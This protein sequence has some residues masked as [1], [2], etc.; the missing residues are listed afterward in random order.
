MSKHDIDDDELEFMNKV[1]D[2]IETFMTQSERYIIIPGNDVEEMEKARKRVRKLIKKLRKGDTSVFDYER[3][4]EIRGR[5][6]ANEAS[7]EPY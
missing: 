7:D 2:S 4:Q 6:I 3:Y 5:M 1:A